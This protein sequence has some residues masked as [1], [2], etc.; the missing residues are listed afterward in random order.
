[1]V[2][3]TL[4]FKG[5]QRR[6]G[7]DHRVSREGGFMAGKPSLE[8]EYLRSLCTMVASI[9]FVLLWGSSLIACLPRQYIWG[10][11]GAALADAESAKRISPRPSPAA[12]P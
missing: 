9:R 10:V 6:N 7:V 4:L 12:G 3:I 11:A 1:M 2:A 5:P 8:P